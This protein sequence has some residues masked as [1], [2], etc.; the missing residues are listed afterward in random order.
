MIELPKQKVPASSQSPDILL[1]YS[2]P[3][4]GKSSVAALLEDNLMIDLE[5][6]TNKID[7][8]KIQANDLVELKEVIEALEAKKV[9]LGG[10]APYKYITIDT[11]TKLEE[12]ADEL[13]VILYKK[14]PMGSKF[15]G[16]PLELKALEYGAG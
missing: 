14:T 5:K 15:L 8:L 2:L 16:G 11:A 6:G 13:A 4:T 12:I 3:K 9:E 7:A 10:K 1:L